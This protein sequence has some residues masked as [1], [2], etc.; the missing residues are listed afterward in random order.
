M[1]VELRGGCEPH[2]TA[3]SQARRPVGGG[4][5]RKRSDGD[6]GRKGGWSL[7]VGG[8]GATLAEEHPSA[9]QWP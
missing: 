4:A 1:A 5:E 6:G 7:G 3:A 2:T 9:Q 8:G